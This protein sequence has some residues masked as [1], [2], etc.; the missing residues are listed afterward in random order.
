M[1]AFPTSPAH[2]QTITG[3]DVIPLHIPFSTPFKIAKGAAREMLEVVIVQVTTSDGIVGI[4]ETQAW[5]RQG[6]S[7]ILPNLVTMIR[8]R[9]GPILLGRSAYDIA[10]G[11]AA[12]DDAY[13]G[14]YYAQTAVADALYDIIGKA[15]GLPIH[16][17][18]GGQ[19]RDRVRLG[20]ILSMKPTVE[21]LIE[22]AQAQYELGYRY[23]GLKVGVDTDQ[24]VVNAEAL[25]KQ[26]GDR[27]TLRVDANGVLSRDAAIRL[28]RRI[29]HL[30]ID[31]FEQPVAHWDIEGLAA[32]AQI[33][34]QS[35]MADESLSSEHGLLDIIRRNAATAVHTKLSKNGGI[36]RTWRLWALASAAGM[37]IC[38]GNHVCT[39][40]QSA[41]AFQMCGAWSEPLIDGV[42]AVGVSGALVTDLLAEPVEV[43]NGEVAV[44]QGPGIGVQLDPDKIAHYRADR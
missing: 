6:G 42:F 40:V 44:P 24:D 25:R 41:A 27:I 10:G 34:G 17:L 5:R 14:T 28:I 20:M 39:G 29:E 31:M 37:R 35:I 33:T 7:E 36:W 16:K 43:M 13:S 12:L 3:I 23:F 19:T 9:F 30:D 22:T 38:P 1:S 11:L 2:H 32:I 21:E 26:S 18:L 15:A 4:G 8:D